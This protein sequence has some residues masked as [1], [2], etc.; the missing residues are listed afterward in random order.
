[1]IRRCNW[2]GEPVSGELPDDALVSA[3][4][5]CFESDQ[6][7]VTKRETL[8]EEVRRS[9][10]EWLDFACSW[11][12]PPWMAQNE[13]FAQIMLRMVRALAACDDRFWKDRQL[14][15]RAVDAKSKRCLTP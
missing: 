8:L 4:I 5:K 2:C 13:T 1:M 11:S 9:A 3:R 10:E 7:A 15:C 6:V 12:M 14:L